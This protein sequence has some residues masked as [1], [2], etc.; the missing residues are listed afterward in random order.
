LNA[1]V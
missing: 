1:E